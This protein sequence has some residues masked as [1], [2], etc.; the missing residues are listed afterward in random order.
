ML[1]QI[2]AGDRSGSLASN[3]SRS[4]QAPE[5]LIE[6]NR[7]L[8]F[9]AL[10]SVGYEHST[11]ADHHRYRRH[12]AG[13]PLP[14]AAV[15]LWLHRDAKVLPPNFVASPYPSVLLDGA[16]EKFSTVPIVPFHCGNACRVNSRHLVTLSSLGMRLP[17][18]AAASSN[19]DCYGDN[20]I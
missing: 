19:K 10:S 20:A 3:R 17:S 12:Q 6:P 1:L 5:S 8:A 14:F 7:S 2:G 9:R 15:L 11:V 13:L 4:A 18:I 16:F